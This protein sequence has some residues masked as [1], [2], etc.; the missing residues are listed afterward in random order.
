MLTAI[1]NINFLPYTQVQKT[2]ADRSFKGT[3]ES[4][5]PLTMDTFVKSTANVLILN[6]NY[7][8]LAEK[9]PVDHKYR[10]E[11]ANEVGCKPE[12]LRSVI[13]IQELTDIV[14]GLKFED[15]NSGNN[16][17]DIFEERFKNVLNGKFKV[18]LHMHSIH[19]DGKLTVPEFLDQAA[20]YAN[21]SNQ[22]FPI[23]L[24][25]HEAL[26]GD[27]EVIKT[28]AK[29]PEKYKN[30]RFVPGIEFQS[31]Y[32][33]EYFTQPIQ[34]DITAYCI[35][36]FDK[37]LQAMLDKASE[38]RLKASEEVF[39]YANDLGVNSSFDEAKSLNPKYMNGHCVVFASY[40]R[41]YFREEAGSQ[42]KLD[43]IPNK[44]AD[45]VREMERDTATPMDELMNTIKNSGYGEAGVAHP[46]RINPKKVLKDGIVWDDEALFK[47]VKDYLIDNKK[48]GVKFAESNYQYAVPRRPFHSKDQDKFLENI[49]NNCKEIGFLEIGGQDG[50]QNN[51]FS[52][53]DKLSQ[54]QIK[55]LTEN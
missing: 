28:I 24:T 14:N 4:L 34:V 2:K 17:S 51:I 15:Y 10:T 42:G 1:K 43:N 44:I 37:N 49:K 54:D 31:I 27:Q 12:A 47:V 40:L 33:H 18:N 48:L 13:G 20:S 52:Y 41:K 53:K 21:K 55:K 30:I 50:H 5:N 11:L 46:A 9:Y 45:R 39:K 23:A 32:N 38:R 35:N 3:F 19:S 7:S 29:N 22:I 16:N 36:P 6:D 8:Q 25:D 26:D